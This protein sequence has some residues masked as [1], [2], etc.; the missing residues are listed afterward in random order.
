MAQAGLISQNRTDIAL[1]TIHSLL[2]LPGTMDMI[3]ALALAAFITWLAIAL[4]FLR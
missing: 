1:E 2:I 4:V 3:S